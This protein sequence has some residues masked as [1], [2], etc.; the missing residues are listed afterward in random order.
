MRARRFVVRIDLTSPAAWELGFDRSGSS[1]PSA[2]RC[3]TQAA[4]DSSTEVASF[5]LPPGFS[6]RGAC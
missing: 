2:P 3:C 1:S 6:P 4:S 5:V